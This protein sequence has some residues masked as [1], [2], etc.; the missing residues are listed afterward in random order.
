MERQ[1]RALT[2]MHKV[3]SAKMSELLVCFYTMGIIVA[4]FGSLMYYIVRPTQ[5]P[6]GWLTASFWTCGYPC[7]RTLL[8]LS[9]IGHHVFVK[10]AWPQEAGDLEKGTLTTVTTSMY[11]AIQAI[12][13]VGITPGPTTALGRIVSAVVSVL[14]VLVVAV[15]AGIVA[16][17]FTEMIEEDRREREKTRAVAKSFQ[18]RTKASR[19]EREKTR[20]AAGS[21]M[22]QQ[23]ARPGAGGLGP[24]SATLSDASIEVQSGPLS[25]IANAAVV[26]SANDAT[27][28]WAIRLEERQ[29]RLEASLERVEAMVSSLVARAAAQQQEGRRADSNSYQPDAT[30]APTY[31]AGAE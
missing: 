10:R 30:V 14:G 27:A 24:E 2:V 15:P 21:G 31:M 11:W 18:A 19:K 29:L 28:T 16:A 8:S 13:T 26:H 20:S 9:C 5:L 4:L 25:P 1:V 23:Q 12:T 7:C 22:V 6:A 17:G 3:L